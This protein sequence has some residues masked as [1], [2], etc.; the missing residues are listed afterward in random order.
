[1]KE[2]WHEGVI[3][4]RRPWRET[5]LWLEVFTRDLG[6]IA[7]LAKGGRRAKGGTK[8]ALQLFQPLLIRWRGKSELGALTAAEVLPPVLSLTGMA[9]YCGLYL[10]E[11][12]CR[13]LKR[14]DPH[15]RLYAEYLKTLSELAQA[16]DLEACLRRF[17]MHFLREIGYGLILDHEVEYKTA[18]DPAACYRYD[19]EHGPVLDKEGWLHGQTLLALRE[20]RLDSSRVRR[21]AKRLLRE[22]IDYRLEG[23]LLESRRLFRRAMR[24]DES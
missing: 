7:L 9:L 23:R 14:C 17:E 22:L 20:G 2:E 24:N 11:L 18:I 5:S 16:S 1:M 8:S 19:P 3:L 10:N 6:K 15:P 21:E 12:L 4:H 13:L